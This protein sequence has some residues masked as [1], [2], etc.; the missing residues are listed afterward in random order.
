MFAEARVLVDRMTEDAFNDW[1]LGELDLA[2]TYTTSGKKE[3][4]AGNSGGAA[5]LFDLVSSLYEGFKNSDTQ[6]VTVGVKKA[7]IFKSPLTSSAKIGSLSRGETATGLEV[8]KDWIRLK[9]P[10][11]LIGWVRRN[12]VN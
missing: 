8:Q 3:L 10:S 9:I 5:Y 6:K 4:D 11:G 1:A 12:Q 2:R 7:V